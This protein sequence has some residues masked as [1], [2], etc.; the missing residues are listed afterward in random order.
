MPQFS[1]EV[2]H[3]DLISIP[4]RKCLELQ[5]T[6]GTFSQ[7]TFYKPHLMGA[8]LIPIEVYQNISCRQVKL[9]L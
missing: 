7:A 8:S 1:L 4:R 2:A 3:A 6:Y 5:T 9:P